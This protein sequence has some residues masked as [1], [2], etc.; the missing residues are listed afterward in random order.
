MFNGKD[1][2]GWTIDSGD[3][4]SWRVEEGDLVVNGSGDKNKIGFLL[5][6]HEV[7]DFDL[8]F[9]FQPSRSP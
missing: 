4:T 1:L 6:D 8:R 2:T 5:S 7:A 9:E 3:L